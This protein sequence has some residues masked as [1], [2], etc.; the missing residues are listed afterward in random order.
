MSKANH[1]KPK[2]VDPHAPVQTETMSRG[3]KFFIITIT[4]FCLL[5]FSVTGPMGDVFTRWFQGGPVLRAT[6]ELPSGKAEITQEDYVRA[7]N[8]MSWGERNLGQNYFPLDDEETGTLAYATLMKLGE[9]MGLVV[10]DSQIQAMLAG[11]ATEDQYEAVYQRAG[12][13]TARSFERQ[14]RSALLVQGVI[15]QMSISIAPSESEILEAWSDQYEEMDVQYTVYLPTAFAD[16]ASALVPTDE[17]LQEF[18]DNGLTGVQ[19]AELQIEQA[20]AF[21]AVVL[22]AE[23]LSTDAVTAWFQPEEPSPE[24]LDGFYNSN[25]FSMYRRPEPEEGTEADP[26]AEPFLSMEELG[27]RLRSDFLLQKAIS[28]L[29]LELPQAE[30][31]AAFAAEKGAEYLKQEELVGYS[32]LG[33]VER[34]GHNNLRRLFNAEMDL[35]MQAPIQT[36]TL[37]YLARPTERRDLAMPELADVRDEVVVL[38]QEGERVGLAQAAADAFMEALPRGEDHVEGD[39]ILMSSDAFQAAVA[40]GDQS[41]EQMGWIS[42]SM[43]RT[44]D[45]VWPVDAR[46][47][48]RLRMVMGMQLD[49]LVD[50]QVFG[51]ED[52]GIDGIVIAHLKGRRDADIEQMWP[53]E[54]QSAEDAAQRV[55]ATRFTTDVL[56]YEGLANM[57]GLT[58]VEREIEE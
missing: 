11:I 44:V 38:W 7:A 47:L 10:T 6:V 54:R 26:E 42:R 9:E 14:L 15:Q 25:K 41:V 17:E 20:V 56:S 4:V 48:R 50:T 32:E 16:A 31:A 37:A 22:S 39:P 19:R 57:Y 12:Y 46:V 36:E 24:S 2:A 43:R 5:I 28:T 45:P 23:A 58:K 21:D 52:Y 34:I 33:N 55:A 51:P 3:R 30:D 18:F 53:S 13:T 8:L 49:E 27:D 35:W 1:Q 40:S 29:A